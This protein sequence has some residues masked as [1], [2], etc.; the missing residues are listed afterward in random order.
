MLDRYFLAHPRSVD[1][2][3]GAH[4]ATAGGFGLT[5][6]A[7]GVA[8]LVHALVPALCERTASRVIARL[9]DRMIAHRARH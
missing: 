2:S 8:C 6:I 3:Y 5:M 1:E 4:L 9:H 7:G